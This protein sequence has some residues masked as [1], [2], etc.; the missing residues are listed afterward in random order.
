M[1]D[2]LNVGASTIR[3]YTKIIYI[4]ISRYLLPKYIRTPTR[5]RLRSNTEKFRDITGMENM[6]GCI[7][8]CHFPLFE[9]P[10]RRKTSSAVDFWNHKSFHS[11]LLQVVCDCDRIL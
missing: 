3:K 11:L 4:V 10:N 6:V 2:Q 7:D 5:Q 1:C 9:K 8:G